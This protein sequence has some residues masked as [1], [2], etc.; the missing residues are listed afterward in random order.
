MTK[1]S[2][3]RT[4]YSIKLLLSLSIKTCA[5]LM[6]L[7]LGVLLLLSYTNSA[8]AAALK[9]ISTVDSEHIILG[10]LFE[11]INNPQNV[12]GKAP[13]LGKELVI[14]ATTLKT[15]AR[16]HQVNWT[17]SSAD[18][19]IIVRRSSYTLVADDVIA[20]LKD[21]MNESGKAGDL[22]I[23]LND[24]KLSFTLPSSVAPTID[25]TG[26]NYSASQ[27]VFTADIAIPN[28]E[29]PLFTKRIMG[30]ISRDVSIPVLKQTMKKNEIITASDIDYITVPERTLMTNAIVDADDLIGMSPARVI[31]EGRAIKENDI[32]TPQLVKRGD[33]VLIEYQGNNGMILTAKGKATQ[34]G[35]KGDFIR[36]MNVSSA[37]PV[38]AEVTGDRT[39]LIR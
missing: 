33:E 28:K 12:V 3:A 5:S 35:S 8:H 2:H 25:I 11:G 22:S 34:N 38:T 21:K 15:I 6:V 26:L 18:D 27:D 36:V 13:R 32:S 10:D 31:T 30:T 7:M 16:T 24:S 37:K 9:A 17:P 29:N 4:L 19:Q 39:V 23:T 14:N 20:A 1:Y